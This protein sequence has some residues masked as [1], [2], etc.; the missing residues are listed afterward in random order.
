MAENNFRALASANKGKTYFL[1]AAMGVLTWLVAYAVLT[2]FGAGTASTIVPFAVG[3]SLIGVWGSYYG[4]DKLVLTMTGAKVVTRED[5]PELF[6]VIEE[7]V[8][9]SGLPMPK[10]AIVEDSAPNA[11]ATGRNPDHALIAF[12]TRILEVMDRDEL[13]GVIAHEMSHVANRDTLV[14]AVAATTA[15]AI[16]ILSDFLMRIMF[17]GG[18]RRDGNQ[19]QNP[20]ALVL[21]LVVLILA[22]I[23]A[24]LLKS[25]ISRKREALADATAVSFTRNPA[26]LRKALEVL[27]A[28]STVVR[29]KSNAVAHIWIESPLDAKAVSKLFSTH[30]P[31][32]E[33]IATLRAM[34][35]LGPQI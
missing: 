16:A 12:T 21:S 20:V 25:A 5:A 13:Q 18:G 7:V 34:E 10:V 9:A 29:Q 17:F 8:I 1:L 11:F 23:A 6:N 35:S 32:E 2:Y 15:G 3:I 30:P 33:R 19:N 24:L 26:G 14:S 4:S 22:P 27:A 28:D 31:I